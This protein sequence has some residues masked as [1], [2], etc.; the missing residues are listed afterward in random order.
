MAGGRRARGGETSVA[1]TLTATVAACIIVHLLLTASLHSAGR[2]NNNKSKHQP[3][4]TT[5]APGSSS[6][7]VAHVADR[8]VKRYRSDETVIAHAPYKPTHKGWSKLIFPTAD[9]NGD[10]HGDS[11]TCVAWRQTGSCDPDGPREA[12]FDMPCTSRV[13]TGKS[14][15]CQCGG[16]VHKAKVA[17]GRYAAFTCADACADKVTPNGKPR[18]GGGGDDDYEDL[19]GNGGKPHDTLV[20]GRRLVPRTPLKSD[21]AAVKAARARKR[22]L[23]AHSAAPTATPKATTAAAADDEGQRAGDKGSTKAARCIG[24]RQTKGC[25]PFGKLEPEHHRTC[26]DIVP[27]GV[28]GFCECGGGYRGPGV[29]CSHPP[30]TC[31]DGCDPTMAEQ[32]EELLGGG[33]KAVASR[34][35]GAGRLRGGVDAAIDDFAAIDR[36]SRGLGGDGA[37]GDDE[38]A[39]VLDEALR[40]GRDRDAA[41]LTYGLHD[42]S[43]SQ[44]PARSAADEATSQFVRKQVAAVQAADARRTSGKAD[45]GA[46]PFVA[47]GG[48]AILGDHAAFDDYVAGVVAASRHKADAAKDVQE[49]KD[50][51]AMAER[52]QQG[53]RIALALAPRVGDKDDAGRA[54]D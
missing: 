54:L 7:A 21:I 22:A 49:K 20:D 12:F 2:N 26:D 31:A 34:G 32:M 27:Q 46:P 4:A 52:Q 28:S 14:G 48:P 18:G 11:H 36:E 40:R 1:A 42:D 15:Y 16:N 25:T 43:I 19:A 39:A 17:C 33:R 30:F 9:G 44:P 13:K 51:V 24:W 5:P 50:V 47:G 53:K 8:V 6:E 41:V 35:G 23:L 10:T 37:A 38:D 29:G 3:A 45:A